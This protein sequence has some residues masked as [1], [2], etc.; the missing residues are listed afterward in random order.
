MPLGC[1]GSSE[2]R[3]EGTPSHTVSLPTANTVKKLPA[4][5]PEILGMEEKLKE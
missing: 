3:A 2:L 5:R 4:K 1:S